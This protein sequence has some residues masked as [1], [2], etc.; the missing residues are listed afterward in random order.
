MTGNVDGGLIST[1]RKQ[2]NLG[3][4][5]RY[6]I[7]IEINQI[8]SSHDRVSFFGGISNILAKAI[9]YDHAELAILDPHKKVFRIIDLS[10]FEQLKQDGAEFP[11]DGSI[12]LEVMESKRALIYSDE[13]GSF[14]SGIL[15]PLRKNGT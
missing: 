12:H 4:D 1:E 5:Q 2:V 13:E 11:S 14:A 7:L 10:D 8:L 6:R 3:L 9:H 15:V